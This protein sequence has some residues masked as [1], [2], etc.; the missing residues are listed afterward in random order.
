MDLK[1]LEISHLVVLTC[2]WAL[3][4]C[5]VSYLAISMLQVSL[6]CHPSDVRVLFTKFNRKH[7][8]M[9]LAERVDTPDSLR[10]KSSKISL[11]AG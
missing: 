7:V 4:Q 8:E 3:Q 5:V 9:N 11:E 1:A 6:G 10:R 2:F